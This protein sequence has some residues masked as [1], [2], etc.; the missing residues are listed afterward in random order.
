MNKYEKKWYDKKRQDK[1][2]AAREV[3]PNLLELIDP[4]KVVDVG[5]GDGTWLS[6]FDEHDINEYLGIDGEWID[7]DL[8]QIPEENFQSEDLKKPISFDRTYDLAMS[9]EV[10]EHLPP[11]TAD[12]FID[13]LT[14]LSSV[15][16]FSAAVPHQEGTHHV[17]EQWQKYWAERFQN[18]GY[19]AVNTLRRRLW[20][21]DRVHDFYRQNFVLYV[22]EDALEQLDIPEDDVIRDLEQLSV[23]HPDL[24]ERKMTRCKKARRLVPGTISLRDVLRGLPRLIY[25]TIKRQVTSD[26]NR[27]Q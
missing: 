5:C 17:N 22:E 15:V 20:T 6:V 27:N 2:Q 13:T 10:G 1:V 12:T 14:S 26:R 3:V 19:A 24:F 11:T 23:V 16:L 18:R 9:L 8:L 4:E 21:N 25:H 7:R